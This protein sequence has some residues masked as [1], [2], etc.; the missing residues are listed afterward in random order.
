MSDVF[1]NRKAT[2]VPWIGTIPREWSF[3]RLRFLC[4]IT[5]G[6]ADTQDAVEDG[7]YPLFVRSDTVER[8]N[9]YFFDG[10][11]VLT[12]GDGAGVGKIYHYYNGKMAIHQRVYLFY[13]FGPVLGKYLFYYM[14]ANFMKVVLEGTAKSTVD[15]LRL[16]MLQDF[17]IV[18]PAKQQQHSIIEWLDAKTQSIDALIAKKERLIE[19]LEEKRA[20]L[21]NRAVTKGLDPDVP[22]KESGIE[23]I[24]EI[25]VGW[26]VTNIRR[27]ITNIDQG[28]SPPALDQKKEGEEWAVLKLSAIGAQG[29]KADEHKTLPTDVEP[30]AHYEICPGDVLLT[31][32][33]TPLLVGR[34]VY[35]RETP[36]HLLMPDLIY[37]LKAHHTMHPEFLV[38]W[39]RSLKSRYQISRDARG[40]SQSM[41]KISQEHIRS[42]Y[43]IV[44]PFSTQTAICDELHEIETTSDETEGLLIKQI[45]RLREYR[46]SLI[47]AAVTGQIDVTANHPLSVEAAE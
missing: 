36:T 18:F 7:Q 45:D 6:D 41:V 17:P 15:S 22:M 27:V 43:C 20:A 23:W 35:V 39:L 13:S 19:L 25:P 3:R 30:E 10:E 46:Q 14:K 12:S 44:P 28:W 8:S 11:G 38:Y 26:E 4:R 29:F 32:A 2:G 34:A 31:R 33:N 47:T 37:R 16:S 24:G 40:S 1:F 5:T 42:W 9:G 21:I